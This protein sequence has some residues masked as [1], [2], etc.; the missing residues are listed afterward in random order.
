MSFDISYIISAIDNFSSVG[1]KIA[2]S[3][4]AISSSSS[5]LSEKLSKIQES[6]TKL[7]KSFSLKLTAPLTAIGLSSLHAAARAEQ[8]SVAFS[9]LTGSSEMASRTMGI[10]RKQSE[11]SIFTFFKLADATQVL[12]ASGEG[13][14]N[15]KNDLNDLGDIAAGSPRANLQQLANVFARVKTQGLLFQGDVQLLTSMGINVNKALMAG[16]HVKG[17]GAEAEINL[18][19]MMRMGQVTFDDFRGALEA[20]T[21]K[22][23]VFFNQQE[24]QALTLAGAYEKIIDMLQNLRVDVGYAISDTFK[25]VPI[26]IKIK[27]AIIK[28]DDAVVLLKKTNPIL[29]KVIILLA[30]IAAS[31]G[32]VLVGFGLLV[33]GMQ[34]MAVGLSGIGIAFRLMLGPVGLV[35]TA[36]TAFGYVMYKFPRFRHFVTS[37][38]DDFINMNKKINDSQNKIIEKIDLMAAS[39][40]KFIRRYISFDKITSKTS[41]ASFSDIIKMIIDD[42]NILDN[43]LSKL[44]KTIANAFDFSSFSNNINKTASYIGN[45]FPSL[46]KGHL[47][48]YSDQASD[49]L[50]TAITKLSEPI[51]LTHQLSTVHQTGEIKVNFHDPHNKINNISSSTKGN[52]KLNTG[53]NMSD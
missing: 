4:D 46:D 13:I 33:K 25:I 26:M 7:G 16:L 2:K 28:T 17:T 52:L 38:G 42:V 53:K 30:G 48:S 5:K 12:I 44:S 47:I 51:K 31:I 32:P 10:I 43:K 9:S 19:K 15:I 22:G 11:D 49:Y 14:K 50:S 23:G 41:L 35:L 1:T 8:L 21:K 36:L 18:R 24:K 6:S 45:L 39:L 34:L 20:I 29:L 3:M 37:L 40:L 27:E